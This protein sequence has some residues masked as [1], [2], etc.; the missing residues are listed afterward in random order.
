MD[1]QL[2]FDVLRVP[3]EKLLSRA[4]GHAAK[5]SHATLLTEAQR[6][7]QVWRCALADIDKDGPHTVIVKCADPWC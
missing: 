4:F 7:T 3:A 6:S 1:Q 2:T 5:I